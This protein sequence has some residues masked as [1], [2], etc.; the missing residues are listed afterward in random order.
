MCDCR[1]RLTLA[2][3]GRHAI[4]LKH[5]ISAA[6]TERM[7]RAVDALIEARAMARDAKQFAVADRIRDALSEAGIVLEDKLNGPTDWRQAQGLF[8]GVGA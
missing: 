1:D 5:I 7:Y 6:Q 2:E 3:F 4:R 8:G